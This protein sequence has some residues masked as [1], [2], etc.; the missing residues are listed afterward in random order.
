MVLIDPVT[1][2]MGVKK[3]DSFRTTDVRGVLAPLKDLAGHKRIF[4]LLISHFNKNTAASAINRIT[5]S[6]AFGAT[7]RHSY[8][9]IPEVDSDRVLFLKVKNNLAPR[10][11]NRG[12]A[13]SFD[14]KKVGWDEKLKKDIK[15]SYIVWHDDSIAKTA[16]EALAE[17]RHAGGRPDTARQAAKNLLQEILGEGKEVE[18]SAIREQAERRSISER[19]LYRAAEDLGIIKPGAKGRAATTTWRLKT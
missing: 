11:D 2:Y 16:D 8:A 3:I 9:S 4:I 5:D 12:F 6:A 18:V 10:D 14:E 13:Y 19:T 1:A 17:L 7:V 15:G